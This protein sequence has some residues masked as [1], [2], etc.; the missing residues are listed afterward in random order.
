MAPETL[1]GQV[2]QTDTNAMIHEHLAEKKK[3]SKSLT[4]RKCYHLRGI[5][6]SEETKRKLSEKAK[7]RKIS[8]ET[9][10]KISIAGK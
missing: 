9:K 2:R 1:I 4:G 10:R 7:G 6:L 8:E 5:P 3:I